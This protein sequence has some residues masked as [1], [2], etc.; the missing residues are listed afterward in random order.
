M[1][2]SYKIVFGHSGQIL[3]AKGKSVIGILIYL[4]KVRK[5]DINQPITITINPY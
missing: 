4:D 3:Y 5:I 1:L 2:R